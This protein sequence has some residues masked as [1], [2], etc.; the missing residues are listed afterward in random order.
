MSKSRNP[1]AVVKGERVR[2]ADA[3]AKKVVVELSVISIVDFSI[4]FKGGAW[5]AL[6][7]Y[8]LTD[9]SRTTRRSGFIEYPTNGRVTFEE[10]RAAVLAAIEA[11]EGLG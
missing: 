9:E 2:A 5:T 7:S 6:A 1:T 11:K 4:S 3:Q 8:A 10:A